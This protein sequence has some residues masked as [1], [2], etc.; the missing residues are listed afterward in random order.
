MVSTPP[1]HGGGRGFESLLSRFSF[2]CRHGEIGRRKGLKIPRG[3]TRAGSSPAAGRNS[4]VAL[5][6]SRA[7][8]GDVSMGDVI[9]YSSVLPYR[10][11]N[12]EDTA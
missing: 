6:V 1:C 11:S 8:Y 12:M 2:I 10:I 7:I 9:I 4:A 3:N 5:N